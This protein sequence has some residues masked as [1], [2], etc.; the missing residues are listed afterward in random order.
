ME[1]V[2]LLR[3]PILPDGEDIVLET[4]LLPAV[5]DSA[6][7]GVVSEVGVVILIGVLIALMMCGGSLVGTKPTLGKSLASSAMACI[8]FCE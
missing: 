8:I 5:E 1:D 2:T 7:V 6:G 3:L 4:S